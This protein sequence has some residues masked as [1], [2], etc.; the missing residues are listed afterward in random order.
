MVTYF[1]SLLTVLQP[2]NLILLFLCSL[3]GVVL[4]A[5]PGLS[6]GLGLTLILPLT[7]ALN[8]EM[9]FCMLL[10]MHVGGMSGAF[11]ASVLVGIPGTPAS[12]SRRRPRT[13]P[14]H[15]PPGYFPC[16]WRRS[17]IL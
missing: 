2:Q 10:G 12:M 6:G 3:V 14:P 7:F 15:S 13:A 9:S 16:R 5:I 1:S 17:T 4:G 11:I 8:T